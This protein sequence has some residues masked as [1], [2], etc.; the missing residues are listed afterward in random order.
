VPGLIELLTGDLP[1]G[2]YEAR[3]LI[4]VKEG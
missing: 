4:H 1:S 2:R 3:T